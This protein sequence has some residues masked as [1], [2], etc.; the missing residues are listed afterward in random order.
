MALNFSG[1]SPR[2]VAGFTLKGAT[3]QLKDRRVRFASLIDTQ[4]T[5]ILN[6]AS[7]AKK[8]LDVDIMKNRNALN[9]GIALGIEDRETLKAWTA[10][11]EERRAQFQRSI[12]VRNSLA[13]EKNASDNIK[14]LSVYDLLGV[15]KPDGVLTQDD[16]IFDIST[17]WVDATA[18]QFAGI[19]AAQ[20]NASK[21]E[22]ASF[23]EN[24]SNALKTNLGLGSV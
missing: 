13:D 20:T 14:N 24:F 12:D 11:P 15:S 9:Q 19:S 17:E 23:K 10:L 8:L 6:E 5:N 2:A 22:Q 21:D 4:T 16:K 7:Q 18:E 1:F 3:E